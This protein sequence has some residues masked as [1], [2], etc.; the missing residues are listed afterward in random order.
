MPDDLNPRLRHLEMA[1]EAERLQSASPAAWAQRVE[2]EVLAGLVR[3]Y[4]LTEAQAQTDMETDLGKYPGVPR[5]EILEQQLLLLRLF[6][7]AP[8]T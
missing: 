5:V 6:A 4:G 8:A 3:H 1:L 7:D 2:Q